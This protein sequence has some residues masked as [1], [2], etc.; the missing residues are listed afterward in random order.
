M[1]EW[2][3]DVQ[4]GVQPAVGV[5][6]EAQFVRYYYM[7]RSLQRPPSCLLLRGQALTDLSH[8]CDT[9]LDVRLEKRT[10]EGHDKNAPKGKLKVSG[11]TSAELTSAAN[12]WLSQV[13]GT[14]WALH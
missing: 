8:A 5:A 1:G 14:G 4:A 3:G 10:S 2:A 11:P 7:F 13:S 12:F 9:S 6:L